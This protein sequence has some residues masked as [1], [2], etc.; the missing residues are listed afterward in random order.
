MLLTMYE[1]SFLITGDEDET[2][3]QDICEVCVDESSDEENEDME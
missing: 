1:P 2:E 3:D